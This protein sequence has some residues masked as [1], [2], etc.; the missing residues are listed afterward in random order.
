MNKQIYQHL[1]SL[2]VELEKEMKTSNVWEIDQPSDSAFNSTQPFC[3]DT[4]TFEQWVKFVF[5]NR[6]NILIEKGL[7][8]PAECSVAP[9]AEEAFKDKSAQAVVSVLQ[10]IDELLTLDKTR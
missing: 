2:L 9:M 3:V 4:M 8:L 7:P 6:L 10:A 1:S 5:V